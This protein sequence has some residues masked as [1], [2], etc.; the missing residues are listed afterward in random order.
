MKHTF[1]YLF[2][3]STQLRCI[4]HRQQLRDTL[5]VTHFDMACRKSKVAAELLQYTLFFQQY[6]SIG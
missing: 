2:N 4:M 1:S 5:E 3:H 6:Q